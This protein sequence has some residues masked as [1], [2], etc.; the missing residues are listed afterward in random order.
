M[1]KCPF[2]FSQELSCHMKW[3]LTFSIYLTVFEIL[4][5]AQLSIVC[6]DGN[7]KL[8]NK[9]EVDVALM[10]KLKGGPNMKV[11]PRPCNFSH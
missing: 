5:G 3:I 8:V 7:Q 6:M 4:G 2:F 10:D 9:T 11:C 1:L